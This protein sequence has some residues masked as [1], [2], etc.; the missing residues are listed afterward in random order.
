MMDSPMNQDLE[1]SQIMVGPVL[2]RQRET[3]PLQEATLSTLKSPNQVDQTL[4][5]ERIVMRSL[6][7]QGL[8]KPQIYLVTLQ[9]QLEELGEILRYQPMNLRLV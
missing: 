4:S 9:T 6:T 7:H 8:L 1:V 2:A 5:Q 3:L